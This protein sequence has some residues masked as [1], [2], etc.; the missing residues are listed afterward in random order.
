MY[1]HKS[2]WV[3]T[4]LRTDARAPGCTRIHVPTQEPLGVHTPVYP[5]KSPWVYTHQCTHA[6]APGCT[7]IHVPMQEPLGVHTS[8]YPHRN[9]WVYT[10]P[11]TH[12][13]APE[14][15]HICVPTQE[16]LAQMPGCAILGDRTAL[17]SINISPHHTVRQSPNLEAAQITVKRKRVA[18]CSEDRA[19][20]PAGVGVGGWVAGTG[21]TVSC[22]KN[23]SRSSPR[24]PGHPH[25]SGWCYSQSKCEPNA[26][27]SLTPLFF[28]PLIGLLTRCKEG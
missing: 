17:G 12:S 3:Y 7:R 11:C 14:C 22:H 8:T 23:Q 9:P 15:T 6:R 21:R 26:A 20:S 25:T 2:P 27:P 10:H 5:H 28:F 24:T 16:P 4:H 1:P 19:G 18:N 13:G